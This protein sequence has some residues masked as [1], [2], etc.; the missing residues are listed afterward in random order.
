WRPAIL[1]ACR[2][3]GAPQAPSG[4]G[5]WARIRSRPPACPDPERVANEP[6]PQGTGNERPPRA[7]PPPFR[8]PDCR[9]D[10]RGSR[11]DEQLRGLQDFVPELLLPADARGRPRRGQETLDARRGS[12]RLV[13]VPADDPPAAA[14]CPGRY[15]PRHLAQRR[16]L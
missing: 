8:A 1:R 12:L 4:S 5:R 10:L 3:R 15:A 14:L 6:L 7:H 2:M 16:A 13:R 9:L 11:R